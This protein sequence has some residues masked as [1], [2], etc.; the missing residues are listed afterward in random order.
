MQEGG[1]DDGFMAGNLFSQ[2]FGGGLFSMGGMRGPGMRQKQRGEDTVHPLKVS[3]EDVYNG[4]TS[5]LELSKNVIC[6]ACNGVGG[7]AR[8]VCKDCKGHGITVTYKVIGQGLTQHVQRRC[9]ECQGQ[10]TTLSEKDCCWTCK[11]KRVINETKILEVHIDKGMKDCQKF[12]FAG[13]GDQQPDMEP[14]DVIIILQQKEHPIFQRIADDLFMTHTI[15][16][17][18]ALCGFTFV[19]K[20]LDGRDLLIKNEPGTI[21]S[22]GDLKGI[23]NEGMPH[24]KNPFEKGNLYIKFQISFPD[25]NFQTEEVL[26]SIESLLPP[27]SPFVMPVGENVEE[28]IMME[29]TEEKREEAYNEAY[30]EDFAGHGGPGLPCTQQ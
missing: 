21:I 25:N 3:L 20:H 30:D 27:R 14:G 10:G 7:K 5:K 12:Y 13:E 29:Y 28:V 9:A 26:K 24:Y 19:L 15:T 18:E 6:K 16:L 2:I 17:T 23:K 22:P 1:C 11:G 4:K 8:T